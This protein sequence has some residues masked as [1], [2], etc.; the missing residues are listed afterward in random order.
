[1]IGFAAQLLFGVM[2]YLLPTTMGGGPAATRAGLRELNRAGLLRATFINGG[3]AIWMGTS[4]SWA[5][6]L[7]ALLCLGSLA[8]YPIFIVRAVKEQKPFYRKGR[9]SSPETTVPGSRSQPRHLGPCSSKAR[10]SLGLVVES[11]S[12]SSVGQTGLTV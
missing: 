4:S 7:A 9:G 11:Y 10:T 8:V 2:S 12:L 5:M 6:I 3:V 1:M